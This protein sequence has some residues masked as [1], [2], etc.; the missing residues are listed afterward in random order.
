MKFGKTEM[1]K[2]QS[3]AIILK[4]VQLDRYILK[5][6]KEQISQGEIEFVNLKKL[7]SII[8]DKKLSDS[9]QRR[10][11]LQGLTGVNELRRIKASI[12]EKDIFLANSCNYLLELYG[13]KLELLLCWLN[14]NLLNFVFKSRSTSS[15]VNGYEVDN[16]PFCYSKYDSKLIEIAKDILHKKYTNINSNTSDMERKIDLI[17]YDIFNLTEE[18]I[19]IIEGA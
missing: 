13:C 11:A 2:N 7:S 14:S 16:L 4:G 9:S 18:E 12:V 15:N 5:T 6:K 3:D 19:K 1:T 10:I 8:S 17:I